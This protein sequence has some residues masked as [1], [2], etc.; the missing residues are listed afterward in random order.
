M[1]SSTVPK[2]TGS[3]LL[4]TGSSAHPAATNAANATAT[5]DMREQSERLKRA[6]MKKDYHAQADQRSTHRR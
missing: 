1:M 6:G 2:S 3:G 4:T 5:R